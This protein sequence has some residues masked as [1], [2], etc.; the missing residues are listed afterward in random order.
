MDYGLM[1]KQRDFEKF[2]VFEDSGVLEIGC[3]WC[4]TTLLNTWGSA[5]YTK[6]RVPRKVIL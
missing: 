1:S 4:R 6:F 3:R 5:V 2:E